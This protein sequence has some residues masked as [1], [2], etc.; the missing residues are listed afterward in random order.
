[1]DETREIK[2]NVHSHLQHR[3]VQQNN[4]FSKQCSLNYVVVLINT[5]GDKNIGMMIRTSQIMGASKVYIIGRRKF[6]ARTLV[7][8]NKYIEIEKHLDI[9]DPRILLQQYSPICVEQGGCM[10]DTVQWKLYSQQK[11]IAFILGAEDTGI[12]EYFI[13]QCSEMEGFKRISIPQ[14][15]VIRSLN[16]TTAHSIVLYEYTKYIRSQI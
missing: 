2:Y 1:M 14:Y 13:K 11:P 6:D 12:P 3:T 10:I 9:P 5:V 7:G 8:S 16:V 15:G 4:R